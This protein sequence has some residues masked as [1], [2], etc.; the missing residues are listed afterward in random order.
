MRQEMKEVNN[1]LEQSLPYVQT[2]LKHL[3]NSP[4]LG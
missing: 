4:V 1:Y 2:G 3:P